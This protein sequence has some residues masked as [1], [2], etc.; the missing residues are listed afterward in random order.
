M[1]GFL[2]SGHAAAQ[3][4]GA[5]GNFS[6]LESVSLSD[7]FVNFVS[8]YLTNENQNILDPKSFPLVIANHC[9][10]SVVNSQSA[11]PQSGFLYQIGQ[12][13]ARRRMVFIVS[14]RSDGTVGLASRRIVDPSGIETEFCKRA[15]AKRIIDEKNLM[16]STCSVI[17]QY[18]SE[19]S[20]FQGSTLPEGCPS[21]FQGAVALH[22]KEVVSDGRLE[23]EEKWL[24]ASGKQV[25]GSIVGPYIYI[26]KQ[27]F[28]E[29]SEARYSCWASVKK[30]DGTYTLDRATITDRGGKF[31]TSNIVNA[32]GEEEAYDIKL[33][34]VSF[35]GKVPVL[36]LS[37]HKAGNDGSIFYHWAQI[38]AERIGNNPSWIQVGCTRLD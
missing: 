24:D 5:T 8:G 11:E 38:G 16:T 7:Q 19:K 20:V 6:R 14:V 31:S 37:I 25:A 33:T 29:V 27:Q 21:T 34:R 1:V 32:Q 18:D 17:Y 22:V 30:T 35:E 3:R 10:I 28:R 12:G 4:S 9:S 15:S 13:E 26:R 36:K 23:I 2:S